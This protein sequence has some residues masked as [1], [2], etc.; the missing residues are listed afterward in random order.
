MHFAT[1]LML[2]KDVLAL[3]IDPNG[4]YNNPRDM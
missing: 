1:S 2:H 4:D 3:H